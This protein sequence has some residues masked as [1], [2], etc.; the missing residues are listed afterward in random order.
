MKF[1]NRYV[2]EYARIMRSVDISEAAEKRIIAA[3]ARQSRATRARVKKPA[4]AAISCAA[5][6]VAVV[7][8]PKIKKF[9]D[10]AD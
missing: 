5:V 4:I 9:T 1:N 10:R 2:R 6:A 3:C 8:I 7:G